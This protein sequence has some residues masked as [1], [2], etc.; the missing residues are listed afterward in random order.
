MYKRQNQGDYISSV[1]F[2]PKT[3]R[4]HQIRVHSA[5]MH[6][7]IFGDNKYGG[8]INKTKGFIPEVTQ[9]F[10][11]SMKQIA[12]QAL[13]SKRITFIHAET[14]KEIAIEAPIPTDIKNIQD[15]IHGIC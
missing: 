14:K 2:Y 9:R 3:G 6:H 4:T 5:S 13:H 11:H 10:K 8:G 12:R 7:P 1:A 15:Q